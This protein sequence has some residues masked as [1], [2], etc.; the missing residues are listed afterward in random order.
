VSERARNL[1]TRRMATGE[2]L[3]AN[4]HEPKQK[5]KS[6]VD[7]R[8]QYRKSPFVFLA[9]AAGGGLLLALAT[10]GRR[11]R[12][13]R[14]S[15]ARAAAPLIRAKTGGQVQAALLEIK[16]A[17]I[18]LA[19][20]QAK[21]VLASLLPGFKDQLAQAERPRQGAGAESRGSQR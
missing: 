13:L 12:S 16:G 11:S 3:S 8:Q 14:N 9:A 4:L 20:T 17:L 7:W 10:R 18:G 19:A 5:V 21:S 2:D 15:G 1:Q 6:V